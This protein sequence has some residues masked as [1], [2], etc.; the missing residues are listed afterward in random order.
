MTLSLAETPVSLLEGATTMVCIT[1]SGTIPESYD[2]E[3]SVFS[4]DETAQSVVGKHNNGSTT[5]IL[6][7]I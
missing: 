4:S 7:Y 1:A 2:I 5:C 3:F 6:T